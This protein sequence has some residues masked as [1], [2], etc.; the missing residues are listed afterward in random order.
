MSLVIPYCKFSS[1]KEKAEKYSIYVDNS[2]IKIEAHGNDQ[3]FDAFMKKSL[4]AKINNSLNRIEN[5]SRKI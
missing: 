5:L 1:N 4:P 2:Y 3:S